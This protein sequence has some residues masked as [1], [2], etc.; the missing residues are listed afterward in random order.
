MPSVMKLCQALWPRG[1][2]IRRSGGVRSAGRGIGEFVKEADGILLSGL[3]LSVV[4]CA[5]TY[6]QCP[7]SRLGKM[8]QSAERAGGTSVQEQG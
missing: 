2:W 3:G 1:Q 6:S 4:R 5:P 7:I 8:A